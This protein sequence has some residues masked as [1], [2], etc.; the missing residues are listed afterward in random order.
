MKFIQITCDETL[1]DTDLA[2]K[3]SMSNGV[4][5]LPAD[6]PIGD[7]VIG[8]RAV[9]LCKSAR[10]FTCANMDRTMN[11]EVALIRESF[12]FA[13]L[14]LDGDPFEAREFIEPIG[15][16]STMAWLQANEGIHV[17]V[18]KTLDRTAMIIAAMAANLQQGPGFTP[19]LRCMKRKPH[20][21]PLPGPLSRYVLEGLP[22]TRPDTAILLA[23]HFGSVHGVA[24]ATL[25]DLK[26]VKGMGF[27]AAEMVYFAMRSGARRVQESEVAEDLAETVSCPALKTTGGDLGFLS[28]ASSEAAPSLSL[29]GAG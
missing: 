22:G 27:K 5:M 29:A 1:V 6:L 24:N 12:D 4:K 10:E 23:N 11:F 26:S 8:D 20:Q 16:I 7:F 28:I 19:P 18:S 2:R 21:A 3:V 15:L 17:I 9:V 14:I 13:V 25:D